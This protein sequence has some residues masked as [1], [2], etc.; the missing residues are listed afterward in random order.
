MDPT[1]PPVL[2]LPTD[3]SPAGTPDDEVVAPE[4]WHVHAGF[5][6]PPEP[7]DQGASR[8]LCVGTVDDEAAAQ[9]AITAIAR[10]AGL[11]VR[12][13]LQGASHHRFL[14]DLHK[15]GAP[16]PYQRHGT[17]AT[18]R[19]AWDQQTLLDAL[20]GGATVTAAA[21][22]LHVSRRTANRL[23]A[24]ARAQLR[25]DS[26]AAAVQRWMADRAAAER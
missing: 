18:S 16:E 7:W 6:L 15:L 8:L 14:D 26:N 3:R 21:A 23:L 10:G 17:T 24:A 12:V 9:A 25:V 4:G 13:T 20:A 5:D 11:A 2:L 22:D 1:P 19:L